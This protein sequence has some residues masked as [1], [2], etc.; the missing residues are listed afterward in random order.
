MRRRFRVRI[1]N[2][3]LI[4]NT[5]LLFATGLVIIL[6]NSSGTAASLGSLADGLMRGVGESVAEKA[7][8]YLE[9]AERAAREAGYLVWN[10]RLS[11]S[12]GSG[13]L[14][15]F[16]KEQLAA[17]PEFKM[18]YYADTAGNLAM[19]R[20][21]PDG[22]FTQRF[23]RRLAD[24]VEIRWKHENPA[25]YAAF[26]DSDDSLEKGYD[27]RKRPWYDQ[28]VARKGLAWTEVYIFATD[29]QPGFTCALPLYS[30]NGALSG[31]VAVDIGVLELSR[32]LGALSIS[33]G[34]KAYIVDAKD[35]IVA[36]Q[37]GSDADPDLL[38]KQGKAADGSATYAL[39]TAGE[40]GDQVLGGMLAAGGG[41]GAF[42][43]AAGEAA[44]RGY[45]APLSNDRG[46]ALRVL[47]SVPERDFMGTAWSNNF[48]SILFS[49][50][51]ILVAIVA[52][53][54]LSRAISLPMRVL[55]EEMGKI[56]DFN[57]Q[58]GKQ[59]DTMILEIN[60]M[61]SS[62]Q[63]M[64]RG[65]INFR[66][67]VPADLVAELL[68]QKKDADVGGERKELTIFFSDIADFTGI[69]ER[70]SPEDL[71]GAL[72]EY[73]DVM[74][75]AILARRGT[76][77]KYIGDSVMAF[78][79]APVPM[80]DHAGAACGAALECRERLGAL[81]RQWENRGRKPFRTR[82]GINTGEV[83]VG[84][85]GS[86]ERINYTVVGDP[87]NLASRLEG[88]NKLYGTDILVSASTRALAGEAFEYRKVDRVAV[89]GK[90]EGVDIY[91]LVA[92]KDDIN[93]AL[94]KLYSAYEEGLALYL[95]REWDKALARFAVVLKYRPHDGPARA[96]SE[97]CARY[98][99]EPPG[100]DWSGVHVASEK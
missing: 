52:S 44:W 22:S 26:P 82:M 93:V 90:R 31:V 29:K 34:G 64:K 14:L 38:M 62:F 9:P 94:K 84:N 16:F 28:A 51:M 61:Q 19:E 86:T 87:V 36:L 57:L 2:G 15:G 75:G 42:S 89:K 46:L 47:V 91:E 40:S 54:F 100:E 60:D 23:V 71:V 59:V 53:V 10:G 68:R 3:I 27:P 70:T 35:N 85:M 25:Y 78:W 92:R 13:D 48:L 58:E 20:R 43:F 76:L 21:M 1:S 88:L 30:T 66:R 33:E 5:F 81:F 65:L 4:L 6:V 69:S 83:I 67:Y 74:G 12:D 96:L 80:E 11:P 45:A 7:K 17:N 99:A 63:G 18:V 37:L 24:R 72:G 55:S 49:S 97:R 95:G 50:V 73:F 32:F 79:G 39:L 77:D 98:R 56:K 8:A 41:R